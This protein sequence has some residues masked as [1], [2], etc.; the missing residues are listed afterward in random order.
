PYAYDPEKV[1]YYPPVPDPEK[2]IC[3]A[4]NYRAHGA[5]QALKPPE[6]PYLFPKF[7]NALV[8]HG[9][10]ILIPRASRMVDYEVELAVVIGKRG[11]YIPASRAYE[12]VAGYT[13][14]NDVSY[15]DRQ[16]P[17]GWPDKPNPYGQNWIMGKSLDTGAPV[18]PF[19]VTRDEIPNP[20]PLRL[21][22]RLNGEVRQEGSTDDMIFKIPEIIEYVS[23]GITLKPGDIIA[24]GTPPGI[25]YVTGR[26]LRPGDVV[27]CE[28]ERVGVLRNPVVEER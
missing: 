1:V 12:Y 23:N 20:Y 15:R 26:L 22:L 10:P 2:V 18:G 19:L 9:W 17:P 6:E 16:Y 24:T 25:G 21:V 27:E 8:G 4:V 7:A 14:F 5:E 11:K 28:V 3:L 13:V